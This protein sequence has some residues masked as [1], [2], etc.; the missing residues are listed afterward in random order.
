VLSSYAKSAAP[1]RLHRTQLD[2]NRGA[3]RWPAVFR[4]PSFAAPRAQ[5]DALFG[6]RQLTDVGPTTQF[7]HDVHK[8]AVVM[9]E[10][11]RSKAAG[12]TSAESIAARRFLESLA[13]EALR[14]PMLLENVAS[15]P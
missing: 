4:D 10:I 13:Y 12:L 8:T 7:Y 9:R 15:N 2:A 6:S 5:M 1:D 3:I 14:A 11:L